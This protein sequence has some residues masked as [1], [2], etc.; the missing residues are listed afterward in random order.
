[1]YVVLRASV[2]LRRLARPVAQFA[3]FY[4]TVW[5]S[6]TRS[7]NLLN[8]VIAYSYYSS[9]TEPFIA[10][11]DTEKAGFLCAAVICKMTH[12]FTNLF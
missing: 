3:P 1:M 11:T 2:E 12:K 4:D 10:I 9:Y 6:S 5:I 7:D 8:T